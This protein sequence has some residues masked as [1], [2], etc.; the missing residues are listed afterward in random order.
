L[1]IL[2]SLLL[3][4]L[5]LG[6][7][8][9]IHELGHF[10]AAKA[11]GIKVK[12]F[13]LGLPPRAWGV[14][15]GGTIYSLNW[16]PFG[17]FVSLEGEDDQTATKKGSFGSV[18]RLK[19]AVVLV[20]GVAMNFLLAVAIFSVIFA[21]GVQ[22]PTE[23]LKIA[24]VAPGSPAEA[25]GIKSG[26]II[27]EAAGEKITSF[28]DFQIAVRIRLDQS[29]QVK[30]LRDGEEVSVNV[31]PRSSPPEGQGALGVALAQGTELKAYPWYQAPIEGTKFAVNFIWLNLKL[32]GLMVSQLF[33]GQTQ[34]AEQVSGPVGVAY[35]TYQ[36]V[37]E[38]PTSLIQLTGIISLS[39]ALMNVLPIPALDGG[40]L[41]FV[42]ISALVRRDF[43]PKLER[44]LHTG[45]FLFLMALIVLITY[46]DLVRVVTTTSLGDKL[47]EI[48]N[49][50]P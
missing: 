46:N 22:V 9:L 24:G 13:G 10:L 32:L 43:Y 50:I 7:L 38:D 35:L 1:T 47:R 29:I 33:A 36:Q 37:Q 39:L 14:K 25:A 45:G 28:A 4:I 2:V 42:L 44:Y 16:I 8:V 17:G 48:F 40:R 11:F 3:F 49:F 18:N 23:Q 26:D 41:A 15:R 5:I 34:L 19:R 12:E 6:I 31:T 30:L 27:L 21:Q 20:A